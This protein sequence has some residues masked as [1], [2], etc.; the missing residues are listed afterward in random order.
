MEFRFQ[1]KEVEVGGRRR[2]YQVLEHPGSVVILAVRDGRV[3]LVRQL[4]PAAGELL[5]E[6][7]AGTLQPGESPLAC[8]AR[9]LEEEVGWRAGSVR[10]LGWFYLAPGYS[11]ERMHLVLADDLKP[12]HP[13]PDEGELIESVRWATPAELEAMAAAGELRDAKSLASLWW[14]T[15]LGSRP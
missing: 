8:A 15:R 14:L 12:S 7:P 9:E 3:A 10:E 13:H 6:L 1:P 5:W 2:V 4:R 11:S